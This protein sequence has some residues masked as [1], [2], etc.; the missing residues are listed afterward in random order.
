M[1]APTIDEIGPINVALRAIG[2]SPTNG[3]DEF[4]TL[5]LG[6]IR[7]MDAFDERTPETLDAAP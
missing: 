7:R 1:L 2:L 3:D 4:D 5:G 6:D